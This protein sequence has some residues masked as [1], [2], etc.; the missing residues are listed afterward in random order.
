MVMM[1]MALVVG[2][3]AY[4]FGGVDGEAVLRKPATEFQRMVMESVRRAS[5]YETPQVI[6]FDKTGFVMRYRNDP[7]SGVKFDEDSQYWLRQ[8]KVPD[9]M[10]VMLRRW[11][12][13]DFIP[14]LGQRLIISPGGLVE[15][16]TVRFMQ[17]SSWLELTLDP[18]TGRSA[19]ESLYVEKGA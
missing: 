2:L 14:A 7:G 4:S 9:Q 19:D 12:Q 3:A 18:L 10:R 1:I 6:L 13:Q 16:L 17:G 8:V 11:G 15:P 5:I